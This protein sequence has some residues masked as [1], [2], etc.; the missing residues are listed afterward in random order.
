M[1]LLFHESP[2]NTYTKFKLCNK[3]KIA[4]CAGNQWLATA[5]TSYI[6]EGAY[7]QHKPVK[8]MVS[9]AI[10]FFT[11]TIAIEH[12]FHAIAVLRM[13]IDRLHLKTYIAY[14]LQFTKVFSTKP[15]FL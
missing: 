1:I 2:T 5:C 12:A 8:Q 14:G 9:W 4:P 6:V 7:M 3:N 11:I 13:T 15:N 10:E